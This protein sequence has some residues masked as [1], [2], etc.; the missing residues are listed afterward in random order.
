MMVGKVGKVGSVY[1]ILKSPDFCSRPSRLFSDL[2][3]ARK[4][5]RL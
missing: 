5:L 1:I 2:F 3:H 4:A